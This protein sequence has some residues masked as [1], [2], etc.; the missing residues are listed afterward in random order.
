[1]KHSLSCFLVL[2]ATSTLLADTLD[3]QGRGRR[4]RGRGGENQALAQPFKG[5][6]FGEQRSASL[7]PIKSTGVSTEPVRTAAETFLAGLTPSQREKTIFAADDLEWRKWDNR[8]FAA[9]QGVGFNDMTE[10]QRDL[11]FGLMRAGLSAETALR[12]ANAVGAA[13]VTDPS[14]RPAFRAFAHFLPDADEAGTDDTDT[15]D[16]DTVHPDSGARR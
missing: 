1:M 14:A 10:K 5:V 7:F 11:A 8:H 6:F 9:R 13:A 4:S 12:A 2:L 15:D 16:T 3:A